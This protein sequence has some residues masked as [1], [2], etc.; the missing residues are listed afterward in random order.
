MCTHSFLEVGDEEL[1]ASL[2]RLESPFCTSGLPGNT[3]RS[4]V[5]YTHMRQKI[6]GH[7]AAAYTLTE[8]GSHMARLEV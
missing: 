4:T 7:S 3:V 8:T 6:F 1:T 2:W 5:Q